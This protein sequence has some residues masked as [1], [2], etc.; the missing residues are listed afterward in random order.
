MFHTTIFYHS[1]KQMKEKLQHINLITTFNLIILKRKEKKKPSWHYQKC[2]PL[3]KYT[4]SWLQCPWT[5][6]E[7]KNELQTKQYKENKRVIGLPQPS[8]LFLFSTFAYASMRAL[9]PHFKYLL[10]LSSSKPKQAL[11]SLSFGSPFVLQ[12]TKNKNLTSFLPLYCSLVAN[13][14]KTNPPTLALDGFL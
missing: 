10:A 11:S 13:P 1:T 6:L 14:K 4:K 7:K 12:I 2:F 5:N 9:F 3:M 8:P